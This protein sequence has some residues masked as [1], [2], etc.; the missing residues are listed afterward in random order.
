M[1]RS[2]RR[3]D[4][5][6]IQL[7]TRETDLLRIAP[8][9]VQPVKLPPARLEHMDDHISVI[10]QNPVGVRRALNTL[11]VAAGLGHEFVDRFS[12]R[13]HLPVGAA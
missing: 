6:P 3:L 12:H 1:G 8:E 4:C 10:H 9:L 7:G 5:Q 2:S 11:G 13:L